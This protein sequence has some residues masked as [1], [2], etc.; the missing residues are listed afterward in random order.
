MRL[1]PFLFRQIEQNDYETGNDNSDERINTL[2]G[3]GDAVD[4]VMTNR[5]NTPMTYKVV[6]GSGNL[7]VREDYTLVS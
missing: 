7:Y 3:T 4:L 2:F 5:D 6:K 1:P